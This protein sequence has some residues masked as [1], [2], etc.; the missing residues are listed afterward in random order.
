MKTTYKD[1]HLETPSGKLAWAK[2]YDT[3]QIDSLY[4][5]QVHHLVDMNVFVL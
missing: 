2:G 3:N 4:N 5:H 1:Y